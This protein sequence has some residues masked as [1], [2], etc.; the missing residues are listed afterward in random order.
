MIKI[1]KVLEINVRDFARDLNV[2]YEKS[3]AIRNI[4]RTEN[5]R[6][7]CCFD[8]R[9]VSKYGDTVTI[10]LEKHIFICIRRSNTWRVFRHNSSHKI[11]KC[12][13]IGESD[14]LV[15]QRNNNISV[16][17]FERIDKNKQLNEIRLLRKHDLSSSALFFWVYQG[18]IYFVD[19]NGVLW[20]T[21]VEEC[22]NVGISSKQIEHF[23]FEKGNQVYYFKVKNEDTLIIA[24]CDDEQGKEVYTIIY[25]I[26]SKQLEQIHLSIPP[27]VNLEDDKAK[28][29]SCIDFN[30][31]YIV[32]LFSTNELVIYQKE[33]KM[34]KYKLFKYLDKNKASVMKYFK[35]RNLHEVEECTSSHVS[36]N[37]DKVNRI[38][39]LHMCED[40][41]LLLTYSERFLPDVEESG[42]HNKYTSLVKSATSMLNMYC[43]EIEKIFFLPFL[44]QDKLNNN[45]L[46]YDINEHLIKSHSMHMCS[47]NLQG[48]H[49]NTDMVNLDD[50]IYSLYGETIQ[51]LNNRLSGMG[52][53]TNEQNWTGSPDDRDG[54]RRREEFLNLRAYLDIHDINQNKRKIFM[55]GLSEDASEKGFLNMDF[56]KDI[57][58]NKGLSD[59]VQACS[60]LYLCSLDDYY[61]MLE[62]A[63]DD[64]NVILYK[65]KFLN[66]SEFLIHLFFYN[67]HDGLLAAEQNG[68]SSLHQLFVYSVYDYGGRYFEAPLSDFQCLFKI[69]NLFDF[70]E[71]A[72]TYDPFLFRDEDD[73]N[74][75]ELLNLKNNGIGQYR[76]VL[77][78]LNKKE[79]NNNYHNMFYLLNESGDREITSKYVNKYYKVKKV[80]S[81]NSMQ[82]V[83]INVQMLKLKTV[84][85]VSLRVVLYLLDEAQSASDV[86]LTSDESNDGRDTDDVFDINDGF[87]INDEFDIAEGHHTDEERHFLTSML[88]NK[89]KKRRRKEPKCSGKGGQVTRQMNRHT[90]QPSNGKHFKDESDGDNANMDSDNNE[91][92]EKRISEI[93]GFSIDQADLS[94]SD[95]SS[96]VHQG[97][98]VDE[99]VGRGGESISSSNSVRRSNEQVKRKIPHSTFLHDVDYNWLRENFESVEKNENVKTKLKMYRKEILRQIYKYKMYNY[100]MKLLDRER[101]RGRNE[102]D[103]DT[104][105]G[106]DGTP[107]LNSTNDK[108][109]NNK[110]KLSDIFNIFK[111][112]IN[113][114]T[115]VAEKDNMNRTT[116]SDGFIQSNTESKSSNIYI[117]SWTKFKYYYTPF[118]IVKYFVINQNYV[119][120]K[121]FYKYFRFFINHNWQRIFDYIP[122]NTKVEEFFFLLP[123]IKA[124][125]SNN[126]PGGVASAGETSQD[127][128]THNKASNP[129]EHACD[130]EGII[131][132]SNFA[133]DDETNDE[134]EYAKWTRENEPSKGFYNQYE[135]YSDDDAFFELFLSRCISIMKRTRLVKSRLLAFVYV[136]L[137]QIN[138]DNIYELFKYD[139]LLKK[140]TFDESY[141]CESPTVGTVLT[142]V[143]ENPR[144]ATP[145][146]NT[147]GIG[148]TRREHPKLHGENMVNNTPNFCE[149][150]WIKKNLKVHIKKENMQKKN[151]LLIYS[152]FILI[153]LY[154]LCKENHKNMKLE[155]FLLMDMYTRLCL[156]LEFDIKY[157]SLELEQDGHIKVFY[158]SLQEF[159]G[160]YHL[161][162]E[163]ITSSTGTSKCKLFTKEIVNLV[164]EKPKNLFESIY[165]NLLYSS[166]Q[167]F[168]LFCF[169]TLRL[170]Q[171]RSCHQGGVLQGEKKDKGTWSTHLTLGENFRQGKN[172]IRG[173]AQVVVGRYNQ[174]KRK[175]EIDKIF[176]FLK[177]IYYAYKHRVILR[178]DYEFAFLFLVIFYKYM[179]IN[180]L[181]FI[182]ILGDFYNLL[183]RQIVEWTEGGTSQQGEELF[184]LKELFHNGE[185]NNKAVI[186]DE[187]LS[188]IVGG[189]YEDAG[190]E[191][192]SSESQSLQATPTVEKLLDVFEKDLN[193]LELIKYLKKDFP[194][195]EEDEIK[196]DIDMIVSSRN[197]RTKTV[198]NIFT[199]F[200]KIMTCTQYK[201][202]NFT[203]NCFQL[204]HNLF[205]LVD[206]HTFF[207][208]LFYIILFH[209][210]DFEYLSNLLNFF[211]RYYHHVGGEKSDYLI[212]YLLLSR[213]KVATI[214]ENF[215]HLYKF[216]K[217]IYSKRMS[218]LLCHLADQREDLLANLKMLKYI[219]IFA[220][221]KGENEKESGG[222][223]S[224]SRYVSRQSTHKSTSNE[225]IYKS[226]SKLISQS[227]E[228]IATNDVNIEDVAKN[229]TENTYQPPFYKNIL[230]DSYVKISIEK[231]KFLIF[232]NLMEND[233]TICYNRCRTIK[234]IKLLQLESDHL[235]DSLLFV[236]C[237]LQLHGKVNIL[238]FYLILFLI[239]FQN[240][241]LG[242]EQKSLLHSAIMFY[243]QY[244]NRSA[245][246][247]YNFGMSL[248]SYFS[249]NHPG[250]ILHLYKSIFAK[251]EH[252]NP[253]WTPQKGE[254]Q[255]SN[256]MHDSFL[257]VYDFL[258]HSKIKSHRKN[259]EDSI[260][261]GES[262]NVTKCPPQGRSAKSDQRSGNINE[263]TSEHSHFGP[264][265]DDDGGEINPIAKVFCKLTDTVDSSRGGVP[266]ERH[267]KSPLG[268]SLHMVKEEPMDS[269]E[270]I[271]DEE[272]NLGQ[273]ELEVE[274][275]MFEKEKKNPFENEIDECDGVW[276]KSPGENGVFTEETDEGD[277]ELDQVEDIFAGTDFEE[278]GASSGES[279]CERDASKMGEANNTDETD[280]ED[281]ANPP[282]DDQGRGPMVTTVTPSER[283]RQMKNQ[284]GG[285][286]EEGEEIPPNDFH[287]NEKK[288]ENNR[289]ALTYVL[290]RAR[291]KINKKNVTNWNMDSITRTVRSV[292][293]ALKRN[294]N[295][296]KGMDS[297]L[298]VQHFKKK[299]G[300]HQDEKHIG[301]KIRIYNSLLSSDPY[302][303]FLYLLQVQDYSF[304]YTFVKKIILNNSILI[305]KKIATIER[306]LLSIYSF[307]AHM[308]EAKEGL[309]SEAL[310]GIPPFL[311]KI[312][313][314]LIITKYLLL[315]LSANNLRKI[316]L[317]KLFV[318]DSYK[319]L[320]VEKFDKERCEKIL[321][322]LIKIGDISKVNLLH[323]NVHIEKN[324]H[325][326]VYDL[327]WRDGP[328]EIGGSMVEK[329]LSEKNIITENPN[330]HKRFQVLFEIEVEKQ[331]IIH[332]Q[333]NEKNSLLIY[334]TTNLKYLNF[335]LHFVRKIIFYMYEACLYS[336]CPAV[337]FLR[338]SPYDLSKE[339]LFTSLLRVV[340]RL[341][342]TEVATKLLEL[343]Y[344]WICLIEAKGDVKGETPRG[345]P[346]QNIEKGQ[347]RENLS[348]SSTVEILYSSKILNPFNFYLKEAQMDNPSFDQ[349]ICNH[350]KD[351]EKEVQMYNLGKEGTYNLV[352][353]LWSKFEIMP[354]LHD[355]CFLLKGLNV[356]LDPFYYASE[357]NHEMVE[358][359]FDADEDDYVK[360]CLLISVLNRDSI[361]ALK[362]K[363]VKNNLSYFL[364]SNEKYHKCF[365]HFYLY[366][367]ALK[368][369]NLKKV[370]THLFTHLLKR[371]LKDVCRNIEF[372][373]TKWML[374][375]RK[376]ME[377]F[378]H[379][380]NVI[381]RLGVDHPEVLIKL[382][383]DNLYRVDYLLFLHLAHANGEDDPPSAER[384]ILKLLMVLFFTSRTNPD[385]NFSVNDFF[386]FCAAQT[387][388]GRDLPSL[389]QCS[390]CD[391]TLEGEF[392]KDDQVALVGEEVKGAS[393]FKEVREGEYPNALTAHGK[394]F[395]E[396][397][398]ELYIDKRL[399]VHDE[400]DQNF[401]DTEE[402]NQNIEGNF[403]VVSISPLSVK[404]ESTSTGEHYEY[405][406][407]EKSLI[408]D[409][410]NFFQKDD[411]L[412]GADDID[413]PRGRGNPRGIHVDLDERKIGQIE[414]G[415]NGQSTQATGAVEE[416]EQRNAVASFCCERITLQQVIKRVIKNEL[417]A[418]LFIRFSRRVT[419][420]NLYDKAKQINHFLH[421][422]GGRNVFFSLEMM[423]LL[424]W[425]N[426]RRK[427]RNR[428][429]FHF[430]TLLNVLHFVKEGRDF[431]PN[432]Q[433]KDH[434]LETPSEDNIPNEDDHVQNKESIIK[435]LIVLLLINLSNIFLPTVNK[436]YLLEEKQHLLFDR[437][438]KQI[439]TKHDVENFIRIILNLIDEMYLKGYE[440][441][442]LS[443]LLLMEYVIELLCEDSDV[444]IPPTLA[445]I[446]KCNKMQILLDDYAKRYQ[447]IEE[448]KTK[449]KMK[450]S[451][452]TAFL[453][454]QTYDKIRSMMSRI[455]LKLLS[456]CDKSIV[457]VCKIIIGNRINLEDEKELFKKFKSTILTF[458]TLNYSQIKANKNNL[459]LQNNTNSMMKRDK[460]DLFQTKISSFVKVLLV[461]MHYNIGSF[462]HWDYYETIKQIMT[463]GEWFH[464]FDAKYA[465][466]SAEMNFLWKKYTR[467]GNMY[468]AQGGGPM[469]NTPNVRNNINEGITDNT[470][471]APVPLEVTQA[472]E[473]EDDEVALV[474]DLHSWDSSSGSHTE[475]K[476][477]LLFYLQNCKE[478]EE[479][480]KQKEVDE[481]D[482]SGLLSSNEVLQGNSTWGSGILDR[483]NDPY[484][485]GEEKN[486][487]ADILERKDVVSGISHTAMKELS[488]QGRAKNMVDPSQ[489]GDNKLL[490]SGTPNEEDLQ[491]EDHF[492]FNTSK[493]RETIL[494]DYGK[495]FLSKYIN[496]L[497]TKEECQERV[498]QVGRKSKM[499][500]LVKYAAYILRYWNIE[501]EELQKGEREEGF[502]ILIFFANHFHFFENFIKYK[503]ILKLYMHNELNLA[504]ELL[505][506]RSRM[507]SWYRNDVKIK[508]SIEEYLM[509]DICYT[510]FFTGKGD[511][512]TF[513]RSFNRVLRR[514][515]WIGGPLSHHEGEPILTPPTSCFY[516]TNYHNN[517]FN[518]TFFKSI[519]MQHYAFRK[520]CNDVSGGKHLDGYLPKGRQLDSEATHRAKNI[521]ERQE[522]KHNEPNHT[523]NLRDMQSHSPEQRSSNF[524]LFYL[525]FM[526]L[527]ARTADVHDFYLQAI[528]FKLMKEEELHLTKAKQYQEDLQ[529]YLQNM[530]NQY[531][532]YLMLLHYQLLTFQSVC[533]NNTC[534][535]FLNRREQKLVHYLWVRLT[536]DLMKKYR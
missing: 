335:N 455:Y 383:T 172:T 69:K 426:K 435:S 265:R 432:E 467:R 316:D 79:E 247:V 91:E 464:I 371:P 306:I 463:D 37:A 149:P 354:Q 8:R 201:D 510:N 260:T 404:E 398:D 357:E 270:H 256:N 516:L 453:T 454:Q 307:Y 254:K 205:Y 237:T 445:H 56:L 156:I 215:E 11:D 223:S 493:V 511:N 424:L 66:M 431:Q 262:R 399:E 437:Q 513:L 457:L 412:G 84:L 114:S 489:K 17:I 176:V 166:Q 16:Q 475:M 529:T 242:K 136:C 121:I 259:D 461:I 410:N 277:K 39:S 227:Y 160:N 106:Q 469:E 124:S 22:L 10:S 182:S 110:N 127:E 34:N 95:S 78:N 238:L 148:A 88:R 31:S 122:V 347:G 27:G 400:G 51:I 113:D 466:E 195:H 330:E 495:G 135:I 36:N 191:S 190:V 210:N 131:C 24:H 48:V 222:I 414:K 13:C 99:S 85:C 102:S 473:E 41:T 89:V 46:L 332:F 474:E 444:A 177:Y 313:N 161:I 197:N 248:L 232:K 216:V 311:K 396:T 496:K 482:S 373:F 318:E 460:N 320:L 503:V 200:K 481:G 340:K 514:G 137:Q 363:N 519:Y 224:M 452:Y 271:Y 385:A 387:Q 204:Y 239:L 217:N 502:Q 419:V 434:T 275:E 459:L 509:K 322:I 523:Y 179:H 202:T 368:L 152:F 261:Q 291:S 441:V 257:S 70:L 304:I 240:D 447:S 235:R 290:I 338:T 183:P 165:F 150:L 395:V 301:H 47:V 219:Q 35:N 341:S 87:D 266:N 492:Q 112:N 471:A 199:L 60:N 331:M 273:V 317:K 365:I 103:C 163:H 439:S 312:I 442:Y 203:K 234:L 61:V 196:V 303:A 336:L 505:K 483:S 518:R 353:Y 381:N 521:T 302:F 147:Q 20:A 491:E 295:N 319:K 151:V 369:G 104:K 92:D 130:D 462:K 105:G 249:L 80:R 477:T 337:Y 169:K 488:P 119:L 141:F 479:S 499:M 145:D 155:N 446:F 253:A 170:L 74:I 86:I 244:S 512:E 221:R 7:G 214:N 82:H 138:G 245:S 407:Q 276:S 325:T 213:A 49:T 522:I 366:H 29:I 326:V 309:H 4:G 71:R 478:G 362:I 420:F 292:K 14:V 157:I 352:N 263:P 65:V 23:H 386:H 405:T 93:W 75:I 402:A 117:L 350:V 310:K 443:L 101:R 111:K 231:N 388:G 143:E 315:Q 370:S 125:E 413:V 21:D 64:F 456:N 280:D 536:Q 184:D 468:A 364:Y 171:G 361:N 3:K 1:D 5:A 449:E 186:Y 328:K 389:E 429:I 268:E 288:N 192:E 140:L 427:S 251:R 72:V 250:C 181:H 343:R 436:L 174:S 327:R 472:L 348:K 54:E 394:S 532:L 185:C 486:K 300:E 415:L 225:D 378:L 450:T 376:R 96:N 32:V 284:D 515:H 159:L 45:S 109:Y 344:V 230:Y 470:V 58:K 438:R 73:P 298:H 40:N 33:E 2:F 57:T 380:Y 527:Y 333:K 15:L 76:Y 144:A 258:Q 139:S 294:E 180:L 123:E 154:V 187:H 128:D 358:E 211:Q 409:I 480:D 342:R 379:F 408:T 44:Y 120:I 346:P 241:E 132:P 252:F 314:M 375:H 279:G 498:K 59:N 465:R 501:I 535:N 42:G 430:F 283:L 293:R 525:S 43:K 417:K 206:V 142:V 423:V 107:N 433:N 264:S 55:N 68:M 90:S 207:H 299:V 367:S 164:Y 100:L 63:E 517:K 324:R 487:S 129:M 286:I 19:R 97:S 246:Y 94:G 528:I 26:S 425:K 508:S 401:S 62:N 458:F 392:C 81:E 9:T 146:G 77:T 374:L 30:D 38:S 118:D 158:N 530:L 287:H 406:D 285:N 308:G 198:M 520:Y 531:D 115:S 305:E 497:T 133:K 289:N 229:K 116:S 356:Q 274:I 440:F 494:N 393:L 476:K 193:A 167:I 334:I 212:N 53:L 12:V 189:G 188:R 490:K 448:G 278:M 345:D 339:N 236:I 507:W 175:T 485:G 297:T 323:M 178:N 243:A 484:V 359:L 83:D 108:N 422:L 421:S 360:H 504:D 173:N 18:S 233:L 226:F 451:V 524:P 296:L 428:F 526:D 134:E 25:N 269:Y 282:N 28:Y 228:R 372:N 355:L 52:C 533:Y 6:K 351:A 397:D 208:I 506:Q 349:H 162:D 153:K 67:Y 534:T 218:G 329:E 281:E 98:N 391:I 126:H 416:N 209:S 50:E 272:D 255:D 194:H 418:I 377:K 390:Q 403:S 220:N 411:G 168:V 500:N 382:V 321:Q 384:I 267:G